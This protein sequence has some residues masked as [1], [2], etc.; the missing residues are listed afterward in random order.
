MVRPAGPDAVV[1][2][3]SEG[4]AARRWA[5]MYD[6]S[7]QL[8]EEA[9]YRRRRDVTVAHVMR[10]LPPGGRVLDL[11]CGTAPVLSELRRHGI[12]CTGLEL[13]PDMIERARARLRAMNLDD[14]DLHRGDC[15]QTPFEDASFDAIV[16]LGVISYV[17]AFEDVL[18]EIERLLRPG[19]HVIV[20]FRNRFN[21]V[22]WDP[23][24]ALKT[25]AQAVTGRLRAEPY[26]I[27]RF[28][29]FRDV[30]A[31]MAACGFEH[32]EHVGIG[33]GPIRFRH[34]ALLPEAVSIRLSD[35]MAGLLGKLRWTAPSRWLADVSLLVYRKPAE[36][37]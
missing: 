16:C 33:F 9:N 12:A 22:L 7:T 19:G 15:R 4:H 32:Q 2:R 37:G 5:E 8:L 14:G 6:A 1:Q 25:L 35:G 36:P 27:G 17:E 30:F 26:T 21:P 20:S 29:D 18:R 3:F 31:E 13:A 10:V 28:M 34:R 23:Y 11:G 24:V